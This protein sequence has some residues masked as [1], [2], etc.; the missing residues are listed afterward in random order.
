MLA[1]NFWVFVLSTVRQ[2]V[3][4]TIDNIL[5]VDIAF[6]LLFFFLNYYFFLIK[7]NSWFYTV[8]IPQNS[9]SW[10]Y[11]FYFL[12]FLFFYLGMLAANFQ[13][14]VVSTVLADD[15]WN[16]SSRTGVFGVFEQMCF[17]CELQSHVKFPKCK[18]PSGHAGSDLHWI[19]IGLEALARTGSNES[20]TAACFWTHS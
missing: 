11:V 15:N 16:D 1:A 4:S 3:L 14:F 6:F 5:S 13:G 18:F 19:W 8:V 20:C 10:R 7:D 12:L 17:L 2:F 9:I